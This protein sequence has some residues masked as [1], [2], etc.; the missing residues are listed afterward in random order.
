VPRVGTGGLALG[1]RRAVVDDGRVE[2]GPV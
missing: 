1:A 2:A